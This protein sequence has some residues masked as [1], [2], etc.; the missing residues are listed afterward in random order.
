[1]SKKSVNKYV[2]TFAQH[3]ELPWYERDCLMSYFAALECEEFLKDPDSHFKNARVVNF[4][5]IHREY[6][7]DLLQGSYKDY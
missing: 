3:S 7:D 4:D 2:P 5:I 1:M 6:R